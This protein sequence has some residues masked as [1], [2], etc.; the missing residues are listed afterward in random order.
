VNVAL[1]W[2]LC[3]IQSTTTSIPVHFVHHPVRGR[4]EGNIA[5]LQSAGQ[6][7]WSTN[8]THRRMSE[9]KH[10]PE[11]NLIPASSQG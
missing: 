6:P 5:G 11:L 9:P 8:I 10:H 2:L 1:S 7:V 4:P 3:M